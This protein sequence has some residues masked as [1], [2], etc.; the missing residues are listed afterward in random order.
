MLSSGQ[1][2]DVPWT[3]KYRPGS[4]H[5]PYFLDQET[6]RK[7][8][9]HY[10]DG[11]HLDM[12]NL[13]FSGPPGTGK[14]TTAFA[15]ARDLLKDKLGSRTVLE[16]NASDERGI[17][18]IRKKIKDFITMHDVGGIP[19]KLVILDE[20]DSMTRDAQSALRRLM[21]IGSRWSRF[22]MMCN[23]ADRIIDPI[24]SRCTVMR[25]KPI[26]ARHVRQHIQLIAENEGIEISDAC[27][28]AL[29]FVGMKDLR[30]TINAFQMAVSVTNPDEDLQPETIY[31]L[32]GF[33][34]P[35]IIDAIFNNAL[36]VD[37]THGEALSKVL[38][39]FQSIKGVSSRNFIIQLHEYITRELNFLTGN[40]KALL[41]DRL[42]D[43]DYRL[44]QKATEFIQFSALAAD[45]VGVLRNP[46]SKVSQ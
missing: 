45:L 17:E 2:D 6:I 3:E 23:Y 19:F 40:A 42:A 10:V 20:V 30:K 8:L 5:S 9:L 31:E 43:I 28:D 11:N 35:K 46:T 18:T 4:L 44:T 12:P 25:F 41:I 37:L 13:I 14:T 38:Q 24:K 34:N 33:V 1:K 26:G 16:L 39:A 22:I 27:I 7:N 36:D 32:E 15:L 29:V 21:E